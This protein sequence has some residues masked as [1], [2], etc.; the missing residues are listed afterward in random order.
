MAEVEKLIFQRNTNDLVTINFLEF[1]KT[2]NKYLL[3]SN[4]KSIDIQQYTGLEYKSINGLNEDTNDYPILRQFLGNPKIQ[5]EK[6]GITKLLTKKA[7]IDIKYIEL[8]K[9]FNKIYQPI[10][11]NKTLLDLIVENLTAQNEIYIEIFIEKNVDAYLQ[12]RNIIQRASELYN[13][14][15][16]ESNHSKYFSFEGKD[17]SMLADKIETFITSLEQLLIELK[18]SKKIYYNDQVF[19]ANSTYKEIFRT[20]INLKIQFESHCIKFGKST[21]LKPG[22]LNFSSTDAE[23]FKSYNDIKKLMLELEHSMS[24][25]LP[26]EK[27]DLISISEIEAAIQSYGK[28]MDQWNAIIKEKIHKNLKRFNPFHSLKSFV[29]TIEEIQALYDSINQLNIFKKEFSVNTQ[30]LVLILENLQ[31]NIVELKECRKYLKEY[32]KLKEWL[33]FH[34]NLEPSYKLQIQE[35]ILFPTYE[36]SGIFDSNF[37]LAF[38]ESLLHPSLI[39]MY[40]EVLPTL[41]EVQKLESDILLHTYSERIQSNLKNYCTQAKTTID[42]INQELFKGHDSIADINA[43]IAPIAIKAGF[44]SSNELMT[45]NINFHSGEKYE[46]ELGVEDRR[47]NLDVESIKE[48]TQVPIADRYSVASSLASSLITFNDEIKVFQTK[49]SNIL[50]LLPDKINEHVLSVLNDKGV[51][52]IRVQDNKKNLLIE[53]ILMENKKSFLIINDGLLNGVLAEDYYYQKNTISAFEKVGFQIRNL[54]TYDLFTD[55]FLVFDE[56]LKD[57]N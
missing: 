50:S 32:S 19:N 34:K 21:P 36:W 10:F 53:S 23:A 51:K 35:L 13:E 24:V 31:Q 33:E 28:W 7:G 40:D 6:D 42:K 57:I 27:L 55:K 25:Y 11:Q 38:I 56:L 54:K 2:L 41:D 18:E 44:S 46:T 37:K 14:I 4:I 49:H 39:G 29:V 20:Y 17:E 5:L 43:A 22:L 48:I 45:L 12:A 16:F 8:I 52:E 1:L 26:V 9:S 30:N 3:D 15:N 47:M